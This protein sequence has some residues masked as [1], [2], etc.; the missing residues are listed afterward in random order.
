MNAR[1]EILSPPAGVNSLASRRSKL[2][3]NVRR[4]SLLICDDIRSVFRVQ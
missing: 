2:E 4:S 3:M 1:Y